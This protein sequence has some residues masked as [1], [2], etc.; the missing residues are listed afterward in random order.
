[1]HSDNESRVISSNV[2][3]VQNQENTSSSQQEVLEPLIKSD[4][5][6][7]EQA[8]DD[9]GN[10][11]LVTQPMINNRSVKT[12]KHSM[13]ANEQAQSLWRQAVRS[14]DQSEKLLNQALQLQPKLLGARLALVTLLISKGNQQQAQFVI[15]QGLKADNSQVDLIEWKARL[16]IADKQT[17][18][19]QQWLLSVKPSLPDHITYYGLLAGLLSQ[20][21][22]FQQASEWYQQLA[23]AEP[24]NA[25]WWLGLAIAHQKL[26]DDASA[27]K[28]YYQALSAQGLNTRSET[29]IHQQLQILET[30]NG[31]K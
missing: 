15:D 10:D 25:R 14:P 24:T 29:Y 21:Q 17:Q 2:A 6:N 8:V 19:A 28:A 31:H 22:A 3:T 9:G 23:Q 27:Q 7:V 26:K 11:S 18:L 5:N 20:H 4:S 1:M 12:I 13:T 30:A 16:L